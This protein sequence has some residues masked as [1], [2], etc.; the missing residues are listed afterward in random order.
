MTADHRLAAV[1]DPNAKYRAL[2]RRIDADDEDAILARGEFG[3]ELLAEREAHGGKQL[4][5]GRLD[6]SC[7]A[8]GKT[9][10]EFARESRWR[11]LFAQSYPTEAEMRTAV[12]TFKSWTAI[13]DSLVRQERR[14]GRSPREA[15]RQQV[16]MVA[17]IASIRN[18][19][20]AL[21]GIR[22]SAGE[23]GG[24][25]LAVTDMDLLL[26]VPLGAEALAALEVSAPARWCSHGTGSSGRWMCFPAQPSR[27]IRATATGGSARV[28]L[29]TL[30]LEDFPPLTR[31]GRSRANRNARAG[32]RAG[33][34]A[35]RYLGRP[36]RPAPSVEEWIE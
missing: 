16:R 17:H 33:N 7:L 18:L 11:M 25:E 30:R 19:V 8:V 14:R 4:P 1:P 27:S 9:R 2:E 13:R 36:P 28:I 15:L 22:I 23:D 5:H 6:E 24:V 29:R 10:S 20:E 12:R 26:T 34:K 35:E 32:K 31:E 21:S 3:L